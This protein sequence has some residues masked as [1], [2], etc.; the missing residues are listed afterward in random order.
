MTQQAKKSGKNGESRN[1][2]REGRTLNEA[3]W[4]AR[5]GHS[6]WVKEAEEDTEEEL[7]NQKSPGC[8]REQREM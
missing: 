5:S 2:R 6:G 8:Y 3:L 1:V 4:D 7:E